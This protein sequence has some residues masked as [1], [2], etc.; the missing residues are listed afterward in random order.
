MLIFMWHTPLKDYSEIFEMKNIA[1]KNTLRMAAGIKGMPEC[2]SLKAVCSHGVLEQPSE[3][4][5]G[6]HRQQSP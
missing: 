5:G 6:E 1:I 4:T 3:I 2:H